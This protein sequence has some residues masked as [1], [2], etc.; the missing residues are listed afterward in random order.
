MTDFLTQEQVRR[1]SGYVQPSSQE[2]KLREMGYVVIPRSAKGEVRA[3]ATHPKDPLVS[4]G[5]TVS[6][7]LS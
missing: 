5:H 7:D 6:L 1:I 4:A 2:R 3:F